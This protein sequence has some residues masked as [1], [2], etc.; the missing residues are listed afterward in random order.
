MTFQSVCPHDLAPGTGCSRRP[1]TDR[2]NA[3]AS[4]DRYDRDSKAPLEVMSRGT[5]DSCG[6]G[7]MRAVAGDELSE[8][9][10]ACDALSLPKSPHCASPARGSSVAP[11]V[12]SDKE[13]LAAVLAC[14]ALLTVYSVRDT[15][16]RRPAAQVQHSGASA[17]VARH[18]FR[19]PEASGWADDR[20]IGSTPAPGA[21]EVRGRGGQHLC[22]GGGSREGRE[23]RGRPTAAR[24][25]H[26]A[27]LQ[28]TS[29]TAETLAHQDYCRRGCRLCIPFRLRGRGL[30]SSTDDC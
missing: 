30:T 6:V 26:H 18:R 29:R 7:R 28:G 9:R 8:R 15:P 22:C 5:R 16:V 10:R 11:P 3:P 12:G 19:A 20:A 27:C 23:P 4:P 21:R 25:R 24:C 2:G 1:N 13:S 14:V 17:L